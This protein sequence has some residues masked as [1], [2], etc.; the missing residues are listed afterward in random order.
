MAIFT[1][2]ITIIMI[3]MVVIVM[4]SVALAINMWSR[5]PNKIS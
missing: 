5:D 3:R 1:V 2:N 4:I